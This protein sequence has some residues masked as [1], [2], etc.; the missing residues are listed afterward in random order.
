MVKLLQYSRK[1]KI[2]DGDFVLDK[3]DKLFDIVGNLTP[4]FEGNWVFVLIDPKIKFAKEL[5]ENTALPDWVDFYVLLPLKKLENVVLDYPQLQPKTRTKKEEFDDILSGLN[6]ILAEDAKKYLLASVGYNI[7]ELRDVLT[8]LDTECTSDRITL[9]QVKGSV[10][11]TR[12]V[13]ASNVMDAFLKG[14][15]N[16]W[17]LYETLVH[18]L[19]DN[20]AYNACY[21]YIRTLLS[22]K[23]DYLNN[24]DVKNYAVKTIDAPSICFAYTLFVNTRNAKDLYTI[25]YCI[26]N[27]SSEC[28]QMMID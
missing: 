22:E 17:K 2:P 7:D 5:I 20:Y 25:L 4:K 24:L 9:K 11:Y 16:R 18:D 8:K 15:P 23:Q 14:E 10:Q 1:T 3:V 12:R 6:H 27:R 21:K 13:Y 26:E 28:L 19:G